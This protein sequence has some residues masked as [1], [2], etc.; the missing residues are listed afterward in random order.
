[1]FEF[2]Q[3]TKDRI[4]AA[5]MHNPSGKPLSAQEAITDLRDAG[6]SPEEIIDILAT[7]I[8]RL[9]ASNKK[10]ENSE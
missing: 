2:S 3:K 6:F 7:V 5:S 9:V 10:L 1:M 4:I 8:N